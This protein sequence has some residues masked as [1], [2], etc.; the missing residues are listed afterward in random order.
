[1]PYMG[2][3]IH[4]GGLGTLSNA[5]AAGIPQLVLAVGGDRPDN[6]LRLQK[7]G[8]GEFL[9]RSQWQPDIIADTLSRL[10][11]SP[12]TR[13]H[14]QDV[15][16]RVLE[17]DPVNAACSVIESLIPH[18]T[19]PSQPLTPPQTYAD[20]ALPAASEEPNAAIIRSLMADLSPEK[21][22][23]LELRLQQKLTR[24]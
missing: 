11:A 21:Q 23:L 7:L 3:V 20:S 5:L 18:G 16:R 14:C 17:S 22:A 2:A 19:L 8:V 24:R 12:S 13:E 6:G 4:H 15:S 1:M 10:V 9:P